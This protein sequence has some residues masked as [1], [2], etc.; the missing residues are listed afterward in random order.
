[1]YSCQ[2]FQ[3][4]VAY[5]IAQGGVS[6]LGQVKRCYAKLESYCWPFLRVWSEGLEEYLKGDSSTDFLRILAGF[7][8]ALNL[9]D[10]VVFAT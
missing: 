8:H 1:M 10:L 3:R 7:E 6:L 5:D 2:V 9:R 4:T